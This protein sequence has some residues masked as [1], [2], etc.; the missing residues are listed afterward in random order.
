MNQFFYKWRLTILILLTIIIF[1][2][3]LTSIILVDSVSTTSQIKD[4]SSVTTK[5]FVH[6]LKNSLIQNVSQVLTPGTQVSILFVNDKFHNCGDQALGVSTLL[7]LNELKVTIKYVHGTK[8][9]LDAAIRDIKFSMPPSHNNAI[10]ITPGGN[11]GDVWGLE[12]DYMKLVREF[13]DYRVIFLPQSIKFIRGHIQRDMQTIFNTHSDLT[14]F[15]R[16]RTSQN[17]CRQIFTNSQCLLAPDVTMMYGF[18]GRRQLEI[19]QVEYGSSPILFLKR[20]DREATFRIPPT[21]QS[22]PDIQIDDFVSDKSRKIMQPFVNAY[23]GDPFRYCQTIADM[24]FSMLSRGRV[25]IS[26]RLHGHLMSLLM[27]IP[28]VVLSNNY[29]KVD[30][31]LHTW[32][33]NSPITYK[34]NNVEQAVAIA[35]QVLCSQGEDRFC[36][37]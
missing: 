27:G 30:G 28:H 12:H 29:H 9:N 3:S 34:A 19:D 36:D 5:A 23:T 22:N 18:I 10:L 25:V 33:G 35:Y 7:L 26:D 24:G 32:T 21:V 15:T 20:S 6:A 14:I 4:K 13:S 31:M 2:Y 11:L 37:N 8:Q 1:L 17:I 16:E